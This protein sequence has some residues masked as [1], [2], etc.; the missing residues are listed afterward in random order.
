MPTNAMET[1]GTAMST[2]FGEVA[3]DALQ[4]LAIIIPIG[5]G[6]F[7]LIWVVKKAL[8]WFKKLSNG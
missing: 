2:G 3:G 6:I 5:L 7:G 1:I 8:G 4:I